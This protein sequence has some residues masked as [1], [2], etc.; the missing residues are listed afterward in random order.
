MERELRRAMKNRGIESLPMYPE[1]RP[2][3]QP[4]ARRAMELFAV[5]QRHEWLTGTGLPQ[6]MVTELTPL[7]RR[8]LHLYGLRTN[9]YGHE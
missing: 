3:R 8:L 5:V 2:C 6:V 1:L 4:T 7:Q 9:A